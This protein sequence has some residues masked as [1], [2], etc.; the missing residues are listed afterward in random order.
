MW[1]QNDCSFSH[2]SAQNPSGCL[3]DLYTWVATSVGWQITK[4]GTQTTPP[5]LPEPED[6]QATYQGGIA[7][8]FYNI[9]TGD[10][11][12]FQLLSQKYAISDNYHQPIMGGTGPNSQFMLTGDVFYYT[13]LNGNAA[14]S[15][16]VTE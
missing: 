11:P 9:A 2:S 13:D 15:P 6:D 4:D 5:Q 10:W 7:M 3:H 16:D 1:R 12:Y 8:G 14:T